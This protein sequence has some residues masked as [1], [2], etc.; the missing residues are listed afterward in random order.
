MLACP[1]KGADVVVHARLV[2]HV[3]SECFFVVGIE[4]SACSKHALVIRNKAPLDRIRTDLQ[5]G[6]LD[7]F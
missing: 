2:R 7:G 5:G 4:Q 1:G 6:F 3:E